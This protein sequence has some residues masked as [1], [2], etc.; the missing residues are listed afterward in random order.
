MFIDFNSADKNELE[1]RTNNVCEGFNSLLNK[2]VSIFKPS[3]AILIS[4]L[5][6]LE[7]YYR[8][9]TLNNI[10]QATSDVIKQEYSIDKLPFTHIYTVIESC[11]KEMLNEVHNLRSTAKN[12]KLLNNLQKLSKDC[13]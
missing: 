5:K 13:Y 11:Q 10:D 3:L 6:E 12:T 4:K 1:I 7:V 8:K 9:K 2:H